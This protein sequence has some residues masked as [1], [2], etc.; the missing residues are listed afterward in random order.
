MYHHCE[1]FESLFGFPNKTY[2][3]A[4]NSTFDATIPLDQKGQKAEL[5]SPRLL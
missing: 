3:L 1:A 5:G 2:I 4:A